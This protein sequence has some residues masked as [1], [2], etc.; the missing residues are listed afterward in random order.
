MA[1]NALRFP[2]FRSPSRFAC[3]RLIH[4]SRKKIT[5]AA[6]TGTATSTAIGTPSTTG[7]PFTDRLDLR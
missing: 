4:G 1:I 3:S 2:A 7:P 6:M 5:N